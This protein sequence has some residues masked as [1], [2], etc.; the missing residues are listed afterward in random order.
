MNK[1]S[2]F[3]VS[4]DFDDGEAVMRT[5]KAGQEHLASEEYPVTLLDSLQDLLV[6]VRHEYNRILDQ[7]RRG[8][9]HEYPIVLTANGTG[10]K[11]ARANQQQEGEES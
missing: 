2:L 4:F 3:T 7:G 10:D 5:T 6:I 1:L 9:T 11:R 8:E